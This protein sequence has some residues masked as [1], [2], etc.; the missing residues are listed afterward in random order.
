MIDT[1]SILLVLFAIFALLL[2]AGFIGLVVLLVRTGLKRKEN[3][4][5]RTKQLADLAARFGF[6]FAPVAELSALPFLANFEVFEG[7][8]KAL[9]NLM[10]GEVSGRTV[11]IFDLAY[12]NSGPA[13]SGTTTSRQTMCAVED[14][15]LQLPRFYLRP[16]GI[17]EKALHIVG[18]RDIDFD[19]HP[20]FS[21]AFT[22]FGDD[23][24]A[25]RAV[26]RPELLSH[27]E[28]NAVISVCGAGP[29]LIVFRS[30]Y[31][32]RIEEFEGY[33]RAAADLVGRF[34]GWA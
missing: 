14:R 15:S 34:R 24:N 29:D 4:A 17:L 28:Q 3:L 30:R 22:L 33:I 12:T 7:Y 16:E 18:R 31:V 2:F 21:G 25:I 1:T 5:I 27:F 10:Q 19:S 11:W 13:G 6:A 26:F 8:P 9:E 23:E 32:A 20:D